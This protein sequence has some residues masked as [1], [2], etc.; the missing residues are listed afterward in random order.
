M[1]VSERVTLNILSDSDFNGIFSSSREEALPSSTLRKRRTQ[2]SLGIAGGRLD[3]ST[4]KII[5]DKIKAE[6]EETFSRTESIMSALGINVKSKKTLSKDSL[7]SGAGAPIQKSNAFKKVQSKVDRLETNQKALAQSLTG[8]ARSLIS[9]ASGL[10]TPSGLLGA[11]FGLVQRIP[12]IAIALTAAKIVADKYI[13]QFAAGGTRDTRVKIT[14][15]DL[16]NIGVEN[17][18][19]IASGRKLFLSNPLR[20]QGLPTGNSNTQNIRDGIRIYNL[21]QEG[22]YT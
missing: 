22:S 15:E 4:E 17:E 8:D 2:Q 9:G 1:V 10:T 20:N 18:T 13:G 5:S 19:D 6:T 12:H 7:V 11:G 14:D 3:N 16:S 21:R